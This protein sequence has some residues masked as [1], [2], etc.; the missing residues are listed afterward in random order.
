MRRIG[1]IVAGTV[2][3]HE[4]FS[5]SA[6]RNIAAQGY[7]DEVV[8][9]VDFEPIRGLGSVADPEA[10]QNLQQIGAVECQEVAA[11]RR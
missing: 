5:E 7:L 9:V 1:V 10:M 2:S 3:V 11:V 8:Q 4:A 6:N